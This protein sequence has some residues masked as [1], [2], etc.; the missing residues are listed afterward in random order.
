MSQFISLEAAVDHDLESELSE[1]GEDLTFLDDSENLALTNGNITCSFPLSS[2]E[3]LGFPHFLDHVLQKYSTNQAPSEPSSQLQNL[4]CIPQILLSLTRQLQDW[5]LYQVQCTP[6]SEFELIEFLL[7]RNNLQTELRSAF[8][9]LNKVGTLYL[10]AQFR[11]PAQQTYEETLRNPSLLKILEVRSDV[12]IW[13]LRLVPQDNWWRCLYIESA[14]HIFRQ[15][16]WVQIHCGLYAGDVGIV[17]QDQDEDLTASLKVL[18][19][20]RM[21]FA[22]RSL[23]RE[24]SGS[25]PVPQLLYQENFPPDEELCPEDRKLLQIDTDD[26]NAFSVPS[27]LTPASSVPSLLKD[28][29]ILSAHPFIHEYPMPFADSWYLT[30]GDQVH[31]KLPD[32]MQDKGYI[33]RLYSADSSLESWTCEVMMARSGLHHVHV[34]SIRKIVEVGDS[35]QVMS[36]PCLGK[37]GMVIA[38]VDSS[39]Q[40]IDLTGDVSMPQHVRVHVNCIQVVNTTEPS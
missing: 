5:G 10:E 3:N 28:L 23:K 12:W 4:L 27:S 21:K 13:T 18:V 35:V 17:D 25:R 29:F 20:P 15:G 31:V 36:G 22:P 1:T 38:Q 39:I 26:L 2:N 8:Y 32:M 33:H 16:E 7:S 11:Y 6:N 9:N 14:S 30:V 34:T 40:F 24:L 37:A 19:V